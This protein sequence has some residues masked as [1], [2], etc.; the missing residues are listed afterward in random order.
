MFKA[1]R[2]YL[3]DR[4]LQNALREAERYPMSA[5]EREQQRRNFAYGNVRMSNPAVTW[6]LVNE[7]AER[8][9]SPKTKK[10]KSGEVWRSDYL[11]DPRL[12]FDEMERTGRVVVIDDND[13]KPCFVLS[14]PTE[15]VGD[16]VE[17]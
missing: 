6:D 4:R 7:V 1:L 15:P 3:R 8:F 14:I 12:V 2:Q 5:E 10:L 9:P 13:G 17:D 16:L 11:A